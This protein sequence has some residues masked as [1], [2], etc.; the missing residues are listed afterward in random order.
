MGSGTGRVGAGWGRAL[1]WEHGVAL[2]VDVTSARTKGII[3]PQEGLF[4]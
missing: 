3:C 2:A 1:G 4:V